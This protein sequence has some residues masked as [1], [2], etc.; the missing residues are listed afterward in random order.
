MSNRKPRKITVDGVEYVW[1]A[2]RE[3]F[4][5]WLHRKVIINNTTEDHTIPSRVAAA[6]KNSLTERRCD[7]ETIIR[8]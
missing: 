3:G 8:L 6:I 2:Y 7:P 5:V 1:K 4:T